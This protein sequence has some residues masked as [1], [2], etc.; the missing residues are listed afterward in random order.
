M[1]TVKPKPGRR[2]AV[3]LDPR[4]IIAFVGKPGR[5]A[6]GANLYLEE[7]PGAAAFVY[8]YMVDGR[9]HSLGL[10][11][12][13]LEAL[14]PSHG[15]KLAVAKAELDRARRAAFRLTLQRRQ[16]VNP[17]VERKQ[18]KAAARQ[19]IERSHSFAQ[20]AAEYIEAH[21]A[22]WRPTTRTIWEQSLR[23]H[24][25]PIAAMAVSAIDTPDVLQCVASI[26]AV[27]P[28][29]AK[30]VRERIESVLD[31]AKTKGWR[32]SENPA[33]WHGHMENL[34][35]EISKVR[36][37]RHRAA[38]VASSG[39]HWCRLRE[40][41]RRIIAGHG[42]RL[43]TTPP[44]GRRRT[45]PV[46][47]RREAIVQRR[48]HSLGTGTH[49]S[50][51]LVQALTRL[52][53]E[54]GQA[55]L[56]VSDRSVDIGTRTLHRPRLARLLTGG[57]ADQQE[58]NRQGCRAASSPHSDSSQSPTHHDECAVISASWNARKSRRQER[59]ADQLTL[60]PS[61]RC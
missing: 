27:K 5:Y 8:W 52:L 50:A 11:G 51:R 35:P 26:W 24:A 42:D 25:Q 14:G 57:H 44:G 17:A 18:A 41:S 30:L 3:R 21:K 22:G 45:R 10:G 28:V 58:Q 53:T 54:I 29:T 2:G 4:R 15:Q 46:G 61:L 59:A 48:A 13:R 6:D 16:G 40:A 36:R 19:A 47:R 49:R 60:C 37:I 56:R 9:S 31:F 39:A 20:A 38:A 23:D 55:T 34:L 7:R 43:L 32:D 33:R 12:L 1:L